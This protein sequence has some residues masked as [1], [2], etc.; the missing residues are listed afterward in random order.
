MDEFIELPAE[1][2]SSVVKFVC[3]NCSKQVQKRASEVKPMQFRKNIS[4]V[5][6]P[7]QQ[8]LKMSKLFGQFEQ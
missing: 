4:I 5:V 3:N 7:M 8:T 2:N 6:P 1:C